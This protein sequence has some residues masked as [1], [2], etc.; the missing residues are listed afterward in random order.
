MSPSLPPPPSSSFPLPFPSLSPLSLS[1]PSLSP[2]LPLN[3]PFMLSAM[4]DSSIVP[5]HLKNA[6]VIIKPAQSPPHPNT[7]R[8]SIFTCVQAFLKRK[9]LGGPG[10]RGKG[11]PLVY[12]C[13][14]PSTV[15]VYWDIYP[16]LLQSMSWVQQ[17]HYHL[18]SNQCAW[19][20]KRK[21]SEVVRVHR[22]NVWD[23]M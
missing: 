16:L 8:G 6:L 17:I 7:L 10:Y 3:T 22:K 13:E 19:Y 12:L 15:H 1:P 20:A 14:F 9:E 21:R 4:S 11:L 5:H 23:H 18:L 2:F